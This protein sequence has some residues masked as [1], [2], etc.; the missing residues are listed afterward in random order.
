MSD[1]NKHEGPTMWGWSGCALAQYTMYVKMFFLTKINR[2][3]TPY[4]IP[5]RAM[6]Q[7][8][9]TRSAG[10][11]DTDAPSCSCQLLSNCRGILSKV[12]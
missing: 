10:H 7:K 2:G 11:A 4:Y 6:P 12:D 1:D 3:T 8:D 9:P 5:R